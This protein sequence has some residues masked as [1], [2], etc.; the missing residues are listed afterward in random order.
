MAIIKCPECGHQ[1]SD[2]APVCPNCGV[3]IAGKVTQCPNCG[4]IYF[5]NED[6]CPNCHRP[7]TA[8][9]QET[10]PTEAVPTVAEVSSSPTPPPP[11]TSRPAG[12]ATD[13]APNHTTDNTPKKKSHAALIAAFIIALAIC[14]VCFYFYNQAK[15]NKE[16]EAYEYAMTSND[17]MVLQSYLDTYRADAPEEH[18]DSIQSHLA[19][20]RQQD[21]EWTNVLVSGSKAALEDYLAK[22]PDTPHRGE[23]NNKLDSLDWVDAQRQNTVDAYQEYL[24]SHP[25]GAH[26]DEAAENIKKVKSKEVQPEERARLN[27]LFRKFFQSI[28][29][30]NEDR[31]TDQVEDVLA[32][33]LGKDG[34]TKSDVISFMHKIYKE[35]VTNMNWHLANDYTIQKREVGED[36]YEY[37]VQFSA[38]QNVEYSD[39]SKNSETRYKI[40]ATVSPQ[41][42]ISSFNM[43]KIVE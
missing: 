20:L 33:F 22:H 43:V 39:A 23:I 21:Q 26:I 3:E 14:G 8:R 35:D 13:E 38:K 15:D 6:S 30:R 11:P 1:I 41:M 19:M 27:D 37:Q 32:S 42:K 28:N 25:E 5:R 24:N 4:E 12:P 17:P 40:T 9:R 29:S 34:A 2:K 7:T 31:L 18:I 36:E 10:Q 16:H